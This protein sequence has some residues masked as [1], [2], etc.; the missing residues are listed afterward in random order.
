K[1]VLRADRGNM[2]RPTVSEVYAYRQHVDSEMIKLIEEGVSSNVEELLVLGLNHEQQHQELLI[3]DLKYILGHNPLFPIYKQGFRL[4]SGLNEDS[5]W[6]T[7]PEGIYL[8][9][10]D[11]DGFSYDNEYDRHRVFLEEFQI[12]RQL[13]TCGEWIEFIED[14][15]YDSFNHWLDEGWT[16]VQENGIKAPLYWHKIDGQWFQYTLSGLIPVNPNEIVCHV[17]FFEASAF[18]E[19]K[20]MRLPTEFEWEAASQELHWG[21]RWEWTNSAYLPYPGYNKPEGAVGEYNGKFMINQMVL[22][23]AA[24]STAEGH[25]RSTYRNF[26]HTHLRWQCT[27]LRLVKR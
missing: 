25:S 19:W 13:V 7:I 1:R 3:T 10:H 17:S 9:G 15:G 6:E 24:T 27:G 21:Q 11:G 18:A 14:G 22:R 16:W 20:G 26:F 5:G 8:I 2:T 4:S 12:S 23:G